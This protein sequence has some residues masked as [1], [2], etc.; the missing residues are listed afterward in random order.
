MKYIA[1]EEMVGIEPHQNPLLLI[2]YCLDR[3]ADDR[4]NTMNQDVVRGLTFEDLIT[5]LVSADVSIRREV[6][7]S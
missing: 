7:G 6:T 4:K 5:T 2:E 3:L 1:K